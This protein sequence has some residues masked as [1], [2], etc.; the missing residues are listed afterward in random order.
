M[1]LLQLLHRRSRKAARDEREQVVL[2]LMG[3]V[4]ESL[5][6]AAEAGQILFW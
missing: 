2:E 3:R 6:H 1:P 4:E 5:H